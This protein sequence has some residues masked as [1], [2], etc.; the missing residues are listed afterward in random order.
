MQI[1]I[2]GLTEDDV[3]DAYRD[4]FDFPIGHLT[5]DDFRNVVADVETLLANDDNY[6]MAITEALSQAIRANLQK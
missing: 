2:F 5:R 1:V 3:K 6:N 4:E